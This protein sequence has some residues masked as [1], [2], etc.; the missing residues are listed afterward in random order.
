MGEVDAA[1]AAYAPFAVDLAKNIVAANV[2]YQREEYK[3]DNFAKGKELH[4]KLVEQFGK[5]DELAEKLGAAIAA[6]RK[7]HPADLEKAEQ[8]QKLA[9][10][11]FEDARALVLAAIPKKPDAAAYK[12]SLASLEKSAAAL[13]EFE[14]T[15]A[16]DP[17]GKLMNPALDSFIKAAKEAEAKLDKGLDPDTFLGLVTSFT[18]VIEAKHRALSRSLIGKN[19]GPARV[20]SP[21]ASAAPTAAPAEA[22]ADEH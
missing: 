4:K 10:A 16:A 8:G 12:A 15:N 7:E 11:A 5:L 3:K 18:S 14:S 6:W 2:Y 17:W 22:P 19:Q 21:R 13:K 9:H 20:V 1:L